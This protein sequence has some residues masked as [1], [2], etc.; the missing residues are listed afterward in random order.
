MILSDQSI[1]TL[2]KNKELKINDLPESSIQSASIDLRLGNEFA[3]LK[4]WDDMR[5]LNFNSDPKY[6]KIIKDEFL[7]PAHS[8]VLGTTMEHIELP[9]DI[10]AFLEGRSTI[11]RMGLF[12]KNAGW[13][14]PGFKGQIILELYNANT[15]PIRIK[16]GHR[17]C[18][19][20]LCQMNKPPQNPY[21]GKYQDQ[22]GVVGSQVS[23]DI[24]NSLS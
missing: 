6:L 24:E 23:Q 17:I 19:I 10:T 2:L 11:G 21:R 13:V 22:K 5:T 12:I 3:I 20:V 7:I 18:Q 1:K 4:Y 16:S 8:F 14:A 15:L 9:S